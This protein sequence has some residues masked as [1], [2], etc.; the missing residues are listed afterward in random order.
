MPDSAAVSM[1]AKHHDKHEHHNDHHDKDHRK[2][3]GDASGTDH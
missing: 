3:G 2:K 1:P